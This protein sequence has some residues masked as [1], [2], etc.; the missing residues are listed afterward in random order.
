MA[1]A[2]ATPEESSSS[3]KSR[4]RG[5]FAS[6]E[7]SK[8]EMAELDETNY[9]V[10]LDELT[11]LESSKESNGTTHVVGSVDVESP[12]VVL[13]DNDVGILP[14]EAAKLDKTN[15]PVQLNDEE[16]L[17]KERKIIDPPVPFDEEETT[18]K[19]STTDEA[20]DLSPREEVEVEKTSPSATDLDNTCAQERTEE[21]VEILDL[22]PEELSDTENKDKI[23][24][25]EYDEPTAS[26]CS[27]INEE[28]QD[29]IDKTPSKPEKLDA[30][31]QTNEPAKL[32]DDVGD[33]KIISKLPLSPSRSEERIEDTS[34]N[35]DVIVS[36]PVSRNTDTYNKEISSTN[37]AKSID[38]DVSSTKTNDDTPK[39]EKFELMDLLET[40]YM[41]DDKVDPQVEIDKDATTAIDNPH[42]L[43]ESPPEDLELVET[44]KLAALDQEIEEAPDVGEGQDD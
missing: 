23:G 27:Q 35:E 7:I 38:D 26:Q 13:G 32:D 31:D 41:R 1:M 43:N 9:P 44:D 39:T 16:I 18:E 20:S 42:L 24:S 3:S 37:D 25:N 5:A 29:Y 36:S 33:A 12:A 17:Q 11:L 14:E 6:K 22:S 4:S 19:I 2:T 34:F 10:K 30:L 21:P 40:E 8:E 15:F 28:D